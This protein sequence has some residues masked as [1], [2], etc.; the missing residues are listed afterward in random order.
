VLA[1]AVLHAL[2]LVR[3]DFLLPIYSSLD[4]A[5]TP[6]AEPERELLAPVPAGRCRGGPS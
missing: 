4:A 5:L 2:K 1:T 6:D 3:M